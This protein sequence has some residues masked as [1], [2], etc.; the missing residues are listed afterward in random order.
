MHYI[1][2]VEC[3]GLA[4]T[5]AILKW[6]SWSCQYPVH[7]SSEPAFPHLMASYH[8]QLPFWPQE[9]AGPTC[10]SLEQPSASDQTDGG[11][12][13]SFL[14][15]WVKQLWGM[16]HSTPQRLPVGLSPAAHSSDLL[17]KCF[18]FPS[19]LHF[20]GSYSQIKY[21]YSQLCVRVSF[22]G[23]LTKDKAIPIIQYLLCARHSI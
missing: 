19:L 22:W 18:P 4:E 15:S 10:M 16:F 23:N 13:S 1:S 21:R 17:V 11:S 2:W 3:K 12:I 9:P 20:L 14:I 6:G 5:S 8:S 7:V